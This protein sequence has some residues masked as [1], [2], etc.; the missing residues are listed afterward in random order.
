MVSK[1]TPT[2]E[3]PVKGLCVTY[4]SSS[5]SDLL[6]TSGFL[7]TSDLLGTSGFLETSDLLGTTD[8]L[9]TLR[10]S[11]DLHTFS[12]ILSHP[13]LS[14]A[15]CVK[16]GKTFIFLYYSEIKAYFLNCNTLP[17]RGKLCSN[18][19]NVQLSGVTKLS[20]SGLSHIMMTFLSLSPYTTIGRQA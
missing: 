1:Q 19:G 11:G 18:T 4:E 3:S 7:E 13:S 12:P 20:R 9:G 5:T 6:G 16:C 14:T 8:L 17:F 2:L 15:L 10:P